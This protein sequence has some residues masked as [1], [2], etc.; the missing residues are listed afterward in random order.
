MIFKGGTAFRIAYRGGRYSEDLDFNARALTS[1]ALRSYG[2]AWWL[3]W[4]IMESWRERQD[5][6][7]D[8][9]YSFDVSYRGP[10]YDGRDRTKGKVRVDLSLRGEEVETQRELVSPNTMTCG[11]SSR[12]S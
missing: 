6:Q 3:S 8:D 9:G 7:G 11:P 10:L 4:R 2:P 5:W 1:A 12:R